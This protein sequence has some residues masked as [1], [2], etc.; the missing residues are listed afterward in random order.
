[1]AVS[2]PLPLKVAAVEPNG[3]AADG[4]IQTG[5]AIVAVNGR[6]VTS[7]D[8]LH[9]LLTDFQQERVLTF[10]I[11]RGAHK[12]DVEIRPARSGDA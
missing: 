12:L 6:V 9:R 5:D 8:D 11:V 1:M 2:N 10:T 4:G 7:V 3:P